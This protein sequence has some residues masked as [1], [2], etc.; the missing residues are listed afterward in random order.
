METVYHR[1]TADMIHKTLK[2]LESIKKMICFENKGCCNAIL[3]VLVDSSKSGP[4]DLPEIFIANT[5]RWSAACV[6]FI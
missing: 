2:A 1:T 6:C 5:D 4:K 3:V